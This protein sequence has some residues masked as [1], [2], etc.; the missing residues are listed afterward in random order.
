[1][2]FWIY[3]LTLFA[4]AVAGTALADAPAGPPPARVKLEQVQEKMVAQRTPVVGTLYFDRASILGAEVAGIVQSVAVRAGDRVKQGDPLLVLNTDFTDKEIALVRTRI[5]Q[6]DVQMEKADKDLKRYE[7]LFRQQATS[8]QAYDDILYARR[9]LSIRRDALSLE[10][11]TAML[12]KEKSTL[13]AP[14]PGILLERSVDV[15]NYVSPGTVCFRLGSLE[16]VYIKVPVTENLVKYAQSGTALEVTINA[17]NQEVTGILEGFLPVADIMTR[18]IM[19]K[20]KIPAPSQ[21]A[22]NMSATVHVAVSPPAMLKMVPRDA[23]VSLQGQDFVYTIN[24]GKAMPVPVRILSYV[25]RMA[26]VTSEPLLAGMDVIVDGA[27]RLRPEQ[28]VFVL[29]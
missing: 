18:N 29:K 19:L 20:V 1:M 25:G 2:K 21:V 14:Y 27:A 13:R 4:I 11:A 23:L 24:D 6:I 26:A 7:V 12:K 8:E 15:G 9:E 10:L 5:A 22:E 17:L 3:T 28:A 16:D